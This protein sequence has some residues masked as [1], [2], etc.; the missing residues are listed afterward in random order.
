MPESDAGLRVRSLGT[1]GTEV[2]STLPKD[3]PVLGE[4]YLLD[5]KSFLCTGRVITNVADLGRDSQK[6][7]QR[8]YLG[9]L[10][11]LDLL[12]G[13]LV[14]RSHNLP[15]KHLMDPHNHTN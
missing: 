6:V 13:D 7:L 1:S 3:G 10:D 14:R 12:W 15:T 4:T 5:N 11:S 9:S 2:L 8:C